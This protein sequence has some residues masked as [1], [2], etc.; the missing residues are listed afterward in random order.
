MSSYSSS[1]GGRNS[2]DTCRCFLAYFTGHEA[3]YEEI[4]GTWKDSRGE[5]EGNE[6]S[7]QVEN[8]S[9]AVWTAI[10]RV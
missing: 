7:Q 3:L 4:Q 2:G 5:K 1:V 10:A 6:D 8:R 9:F